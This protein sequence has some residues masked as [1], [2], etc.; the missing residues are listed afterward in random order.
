M[1]RTNFELRTRSHVTRLNL[2]PYGLRAIG[3]TYID[4][5]GA[6]VEQPA[7]LVVLCAYQFHNVRLLLLSKIGKPYARALARG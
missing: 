6:E 3:V 4:A 5:Q 2:S 7:D 1:L